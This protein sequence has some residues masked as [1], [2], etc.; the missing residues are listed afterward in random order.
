MN[1]GSVIIAMQ[2]A[3]HASRFLFEAC[4]RA[5]MVAKLPAQTSSSAPLS[6][7]PHIRVDR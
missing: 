7:W 3:P 1:R 5:A 2:I 4:A 6:G